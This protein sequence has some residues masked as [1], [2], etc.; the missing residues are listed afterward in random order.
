MTTNHITMR[1]IDEETTEVWA[2][3]EYVATLTHDEHGWA[4]INCVE[5]VIRDIAR[6]LGAEFSRGDA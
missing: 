2:N 1:D 6:V 5:R 3:G 4:G